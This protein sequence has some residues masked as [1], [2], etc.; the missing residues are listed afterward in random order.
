MNL[1]TVCK[2]HSLSYN[3]YLYFSSGNATAVLSRGYKMTQCYICICI[4]TLMTQIPDRSLLIFISEVI[5][6]SHNRDSEFCLPQEERNPVRMRSQR[7][8]VFRTYAGGAPLCRQVCSGFT[9][10]TAY[11]LLSS[12]LYNYK[13]QLNL[14]P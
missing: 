13:S 8:L 1:R 10:V 4:C 11:Q 6:R 12:V 14:E 2:L 7:S 9:D 3:R 5:P